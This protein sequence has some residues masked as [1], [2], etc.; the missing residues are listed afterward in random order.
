M[1]LG[2]KSCTTNRVR[3][4]FYNNG[5][6]EVFG[7]KLFGTYHDVLHTNDGFLPLGVHKDNAG[8]VEDTMLNIAVGAPYSEALNDHHDPLDNW[9]YD[10]ARPSD[11]YGSYT[12]SSLDLTG[13]YVRNCQTGV[14]TDIWAT[15]YAPREWPLT[16]DTTAKTFRFYLGDWP[17]TQRGFSDPTFDCWNDPNDFLMVDPNNDDVGVK[18]MHNGT[19][20]FAYV[21]TQK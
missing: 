18:V 1:V 10:H 19:S 9:I 4:N 14:W 6:V 2:G 3:V 5:A 7:L 8:A 17:D 21:A 20:W 15:S 11:W 12:R 13:M 16:V